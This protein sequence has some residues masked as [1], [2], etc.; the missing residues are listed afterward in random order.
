MAFANSVKYFVF[1]ALLINFS[2]AQIRVSI[3]EQ[4]IERGRLDTIE[5]LGDFGSQSFNKITLVFQFNAYL[6]DIQNVVSDANNIISES[7]PN[8]SVQLNQL[9]DAIL[10]ITS[11]Q[12]NISPNVEKTLCKL[13]V[14]GLVYKD[15]ISTIRLLQLEIDDNP[16]DFTFEGGTV[17]VRGPLVFP[18]K[19]NYLSESFPVPS[20]DRVFFRFGLTSSSKIELKVFNAK[21]EEVLTSNN[22]EFFKIIG[23]KGEIS[24]EEKLESGDYLLELSFPLNYASGCYFLQLNA[25]SIGV[26]NSKFL[27][28]K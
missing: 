12:L 18:V 24:P 22:S 9:N 28:V 14:E 11:S 8:F 1:I 17:K 25:F 2:F 26:L 19:E 6:I 16:V 4:V 3:P 10:R 13:I 21:G 27:I 5:I 20:T 15:S 7:K 23:T